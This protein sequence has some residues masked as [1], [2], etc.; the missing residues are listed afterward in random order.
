MTDKPKPGRQRRLGSQR[1]WLRISAALAVVGLV[2]AVVCTGV[3]GYQ[4]YDAKFNV[5]ATQQARDDAQDGAEQVMLNVTNID[6][7]NMTAYREQLNSSLVDEAANQVTPETFQQLV[8]EGEANGGA[9]AKLTSSIVRSGVVEF[10]KEDET[11]KVIVYVE[12]V[13][14]V[15]NQEP[16]TLQSGFSVGVRKVDGAWKASDIQPL[17]AFALQD[18]AAGAPAPADPSAVPAPATTAPGGN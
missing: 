5:Q 10:N 2:A 16:V 18:P 9:S 17:D 7:A 15:A 1:L 3:F 13:R 12:S 4:W 8:T 6:P 14:S 11:A